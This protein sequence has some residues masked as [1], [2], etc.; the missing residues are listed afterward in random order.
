MKLR[1]QFGLAEPAREATWWQPITSFPP[2]VT[3]KNKKWEFTMYAPDIAN[4]VEY[5]CY[6]SEIATYDPNWHATTYESIDNLFITGS[7]IGCE[8]ECLAELSDLLL[9]SHLFQQIVCPGLNGSITR[10]HWVLSCNRNWHQKER[11]GCTN[12][13]GLQPS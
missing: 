11:R 8:C 2:L 13:Q 7:G 5:I 9:C 4:K 6:F 1:L 10:P 12:R 3:Y